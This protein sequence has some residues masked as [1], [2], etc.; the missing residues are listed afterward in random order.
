M[1]IFYRVPNAEAFKTSA[2]Q[3]RPELL[4]AMRVGQHGG[5]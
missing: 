1:V 5:A 4:P 2:G 3:T